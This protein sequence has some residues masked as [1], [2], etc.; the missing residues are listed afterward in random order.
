[1]RFQSLRTRLLIGFAALFV[2]AMAV[3]GWALIAEARAR[4]AQFELEQARYQVKTLAEASVDAVIAQDFELMERWLHA[5][6][7]SARYAYAALVRLDG[8]VLT[9]SEH[10]FIGR[11]V[12]TP[13]APV[14]DDIVSE[15]RSREV[16]EL[17][18]PVL[19]G[20]KHLANAHIA[21]YANS[22]S[23]GIVEILKKIFLIFSLLLS[24]LA[25][26][27]M[28]ISRKIVAPIETL[29]A[30]VKG[31]SFESP[32]R[33]ELSLH[34][35]PDEVGQLASAFNV[36]LQRLAQSYADV[37]NANAILERRVEERTLEL[38]QAMK[39]LKDSHAR[40]A[41]IM[42]NVAEGI[43]TFDQRGNIESYNPSA[44]ALFG[45]ASDELIGRSFDSLFSRKEEHEATEI[46]SQ[47]FVNATAL[48]EG[49]ETREVSI[50]RKDGMLLTIEV[51][52]SSVD[53]EGVTTYIGV[54]R[55]VTERRLMVDQL[56]YV[57][58]H[59][60]LTGLYSRGY[61]CGE[62]E[63]VILRA[64]RKGERCA[65]LF[66][67]LDK[68]KLVND[69]LGHAAGDQVL[70]DI[71]RI[72]SQRARKSDIVA[73]L[74]GDEFAILLY[75]ITVELAQRV[76]DSFRQQVLEYRLEVNGVAIDV[77][78]SIGVVY[79][80]NDA[81]SVEDVMAKADSACYDAKRDGR[82]AVRVYRQ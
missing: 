37:K 76:A 68:F 50:R 64:H 52:V 21:Y 36:L 48:K 2:C 11:A 58:E 54:I 8:K 3:L 44:L 19:A 46:S 75:N 29:T 4:Q 55:D 72:L 59:D 78:C 56:R 20:N 9:H 28:F 26:G 70:I 13:G 60:A 49:R 12:T 40:T 77:G 74:G 1:M 14:T 22:D 73:R 51:G 47:S 18:H 81:V 41:A 23:T 27:A 57:A 5:A 7:P 38:V 82:N 10:Y 15:Y 42:N 25:I 16:R 43:V 80:D 53:F 79:I 34:S 61:F 45:N 65:L 17:H 24:T 6:M 66:I 32:T 62:L 67:D 31:A 33:L 30:A 35:R 39:N 69:T 63:R 71:A